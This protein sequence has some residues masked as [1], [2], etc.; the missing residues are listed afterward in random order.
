MEESQAHR[1]LIEASPDLL[2]ALQDMFALMDEGWLVR[3]TNDD[4]KDGWA[5]RQMAAV[6]RLA[7]ARAAI[8]KTRAVLAK[9]KG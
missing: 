5:M 1:A 7:Q 8:S 6:K 3:N 4:A 2:E 9:G